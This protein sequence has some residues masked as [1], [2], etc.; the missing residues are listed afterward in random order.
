MAEYD[1]DDMDNDN[2][3]GRYCCMHR[4]WYLLFFAIA[5]FLYGL[6]NSLYYV[7]WAY[8]YY[9]NMRQSN[10]S[11]PGC[12][13]IFTCGSTINS[14]YEFRVCVLTIGSLVFGVIGI[15]AT[16]QRYATDML[17]FALWICAVAFVHLFCLCADLMYTAI[18][19]S[20]Y[21]KNLVYE[22]LLWPIPRWPVSK[23]VKY[24]IR[25]LDSY[26]S[27]YVDQFAHY[28]VA[29]F[30]GLIVFVKLAFE[31]FMA[32]QA[33]ILAQRFHYGLA[34]MG[35][36]FSIEGWRKR[37]MLRYEINEVA[38]NTFDM[39]CATGMDVGWT[40]DEYILQRPLRQPHWYRGGMAGGMMM[41]AGA[42]QAYDGFRDD[43]RN[44]LL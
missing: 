8:L 7:T 22:A 12:S 40:A 5:V 23:T 39:A 25:T 17:S 10:C 43:R 38:Y 34:G 27:A 26:P 20:H 32:V 2:A 41:P 37:L 13:D 6:Y 3:F 14:S 42:A 31:I 11:G 33:F 4:R 28:N 29:A 30:Y 24:E 21:P 35:I 15:G 16:L 44:V 18:C 19:D 9:G 1:D 36:N